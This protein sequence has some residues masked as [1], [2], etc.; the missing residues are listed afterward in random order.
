MKINADI[1]QIMMEDETGYLSRETEKE[2]VKVERLKRLLSKI[3]LDLN[4]KKVTTIVGK[5]I[6]S[7][8]MLTHNIHFGLNSRG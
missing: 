8:I 3:L 6:K 2:E 7:H 1:F 5:D 4:E